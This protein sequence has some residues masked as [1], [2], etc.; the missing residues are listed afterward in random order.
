MRSGVTA[1]K[2]NR[3]ADGRRFYHQYDLKVFNT[4]KPKAVSL[5]IDNES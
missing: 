1:T 3:K 4:P 2:S 5:S